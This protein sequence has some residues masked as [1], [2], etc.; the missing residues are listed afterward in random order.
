MNWLIVIIC[1]SLAGLF[2]AIACFEEG[3]GRWVAVAI[4][5]VFCM[6]AL[7]VRV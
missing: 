6:A 7:V 3:H 2:G 5:T 1:L 4:T